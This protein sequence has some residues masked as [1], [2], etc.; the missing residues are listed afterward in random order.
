[1]EEIKHELRLLQMLGCGAYKKYNSNK[2]IIQD[3]KIRPYKTIGEIARKRNKSRNATSPYIYITKF[4][5]EDV[6]YMSSRDFDDEKNNFCYNFKVKKA[7]QDAYDVFISCGKNPK[8]SIWSYKSEDVFAEFAIS[9]NAFFVDFVRRTEN[10][11]VQEVVTFNWEPSGSDK[12]EYSYQMRHCKRPSS[13]GITT[14]A[15]SAEQDRQRFGEGVSLLSVETWENRGLSERESNMAECS[16]EDAI[17]ENEMGTDAIDA[18]RSVLNKVLPFKE[19]DALNV[20]LKDYEFPENVQKELEW[21]MPDIY[22]SK[23]YQKEH[24]ST[25]RNLSRKNQIK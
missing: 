25:S 9:N 1:M 10:F 15:F 14:Y 7:G 4:E 13:S 5:S 11:S 3:K 22:E 21:F 12:K 2:W 16:V 18:F 20:L 19:E 17:R 8:V 24:K 6:S 23:K